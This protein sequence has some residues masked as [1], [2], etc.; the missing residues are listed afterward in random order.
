MLN[1]LE[2]FY[3]TDY[4]VDPR[5][6]PNLAKI[7]QVFIRA[8]AFNA[9][10]PLRVATVA[11]E[12]GMDSSQLSRLLKRRVGFTRVES[13]R[14][15]L[16]YYYWKSFQMKATE[17]GNPGYPHNLHALSAEEVPAV[18]MVTPDIVPTGGEHG[19]VVAGVANTAPMPNRSHTCKWQ[20]F[21]TVP[22]EAIQKLWDKGRIEFDIKGDLP[23]VIRQLIT[24]S[25]WAERKG[26]YNGESDENS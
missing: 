21:D 23:N 2:T 10:K 18:I 7:A 19:K 5:A 4:T 3:P 17:E 9:N 16:G 24:L 8:K 11:K 13:I 15:T 20:P 12:L 6:L 25:E 22:D 1:T 26:L 14:G